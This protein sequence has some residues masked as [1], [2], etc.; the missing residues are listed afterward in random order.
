MDFFY[1]VRFPLMAM[2]MLSLLTG[3]WA[4]LLRFGWDFP[5]PIAHLAAIHG[6]LM[7]CG[8]LGTVIGLERAVALGRPW[9]YAAP[10]FAALG[11]VT[12]L[13]LD[14]AKTGIALFIVSSVLLA[15][16][17]AAILS[18][19]FAMFNVTMALGALA[20][21]AG[22]LLWFIGRPVED[23]VLWWAAF[24]IL[25]IA[26]ERLEL[27]RFMEPPPVARR[28]FPAAIGVLLAGSVLT[29]V[30]SATGIKAAA[31]GMLF[32]ALWL[33]RF[34]IARR[35]VRQTGLTRFVAICLL[36]GYFWLG[37]GGVLLFPQPAWGPGNGYDA[38]LHCVFL[39]FAFSMIFGHAPIIFP[40][41]LRVA[42]P[43]RPAFYVHFA[44]LQAT[45]LLRV[46][47][48]VMGWESGRM[49]GGLLNALALV[50]FLINTVISVRRG[51][52]NT[53]ER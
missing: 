11:G 9:G 30:S 7:V 24:V 23:F 37:L 14:D 2:G 31:L 35:T 44:V 21:M 3:I 19:Q 48:D 50:A 51:R 20:W 32:T 18:K 29:T 17:Y 4:G 38:V 15:A 12:V 16:I 43:Y 36:S 13:V 26:G 5:T 46:A 42:V 34:D 52:G 27:S 41:V 8:F 33:A 10:L 49:W 40:A 6:P 22:N 25:T 1:R 53:V 39:G 28:L 45:L 47:S